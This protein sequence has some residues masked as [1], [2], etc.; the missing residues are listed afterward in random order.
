MTISIVHFSSV[1]GE[2]AYLRSPTSTQMVPE[3]RPGCLAMKLASEKGMESRVDDTEGPRLYVSG[4]DLRMS[5]ARGCDWTN[6][7]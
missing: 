1:D 4:R 3:I 7:E 6:E 5:Q 2:F